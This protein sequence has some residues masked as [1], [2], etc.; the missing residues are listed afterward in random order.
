MI[1]FPQAGAISPRSTF[2]NIRAVRLVSG[3]RVSHNSDVAIIKWRS[4]IY[5]GPTVP[6][7]GEGT[8]VQWPVGLGGKENEGVSAIAARKLGG[9]GYV[10]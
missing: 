5:R 1:L 4:L 3:V 10:E 2:R 8:S 6:E 9:I 7:V